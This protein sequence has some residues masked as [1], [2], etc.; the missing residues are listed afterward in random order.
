M[1][2]AIVHYSNLTHLIASFPFFQVS[3][4]ITATVQSLFTNQ[5]CACSDYGLPI[6]ILQ[7]VS[8]GLIRWPQIY[9][10]HL[11]DFEANSVTF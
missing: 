3:P 2:L 7:A 5:N 11:Q 4:L 6:W 1:L 9:S 8:V 10:C